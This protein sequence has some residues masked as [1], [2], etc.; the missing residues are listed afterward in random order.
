MDEAIELNS[1]LDE[2]NDF[3]TD[4]ILCLESVQLTSQSLHPELCE[5]TS[6]M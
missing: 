5:S 4:L 2:I 3:R 6:T 1:L